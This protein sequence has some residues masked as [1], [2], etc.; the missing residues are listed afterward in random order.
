MLI[1]NNSLRGLFLKI[2]GL[3]RIGCI[4]F[5]FYYMLSSGK[6]N[7][8]ASSLSL[9]VWLSFSLLLYF[10]LLSHTRYLTALLIFDYLAVLLYPYF[11][12]YNILPELIYIPGI[13]FAISLTLPKLPGAAAV[14]LLGIPGA[15]TLS[16]GF[17]SDITFS[18]NGN[19]IPYYA[20][21]M[22]FYIPI[23][24]LVLVF[25]GIYYELEKAKKSSAEFEQI[26]I[27]LHQ[28]NHSISE[29]IFSLQNNMTLE[30]RK[31]LSKEIHDTAGYV[32]VN[33]IMM[34]QAA[35]AVFTKDT[36]KAQKLIEDARD[37]AERGINEIRHQLRD[38]RAYTPPRFSLQNDL[39]NVGETFHKATDVEI[40][41]N[42]GNWPQTLSGKMDSFYIS[43]MQ[44]ALTNALK[45]GHATA[46]SVMCWCDPLQFSMTVRDNGSGTVLPMKFGIG[47]TA[48]EDV[49]NQLQGSINIITDKSGFSISAVIPREAVNIDG[50]WAG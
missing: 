33:L 2:L 26:N 27:H 47:I 12:P 35:S 48:M 21:A 6:I 42:Y 23:I 14:I 28:L 19:A 36:G 1:K 8:S 50:A 45:H 39:L 24:F 25:M 34:L 16:W 5:L 9:L 37:Y 22:V 29:R 49:V 11:E 7:G 13:L 15:I 20:A 4:V 41:I 46:V 38:I 18:L 17:T 43:F 31:R 30:E 3:Y 10:A 32:F 40:S 44:E